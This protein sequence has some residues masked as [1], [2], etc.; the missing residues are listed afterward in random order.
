MDWLTQERPAGSFMR[1]LSL[2]DGI[3]A[4]SITATYEN[5]VLSVTI[6]V[7]E[8]AKPRKIEVGSSSGRGSSIPVEQAH[9]AS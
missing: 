7:S 6:P 4:D 2:G 8:K 1:Q 9:T 5:G 3:D